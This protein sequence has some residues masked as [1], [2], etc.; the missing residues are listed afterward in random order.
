MVYT[1][2]LQLNMGLMQASKQAKGSLT[3]LNS[4][5]EQLTTQ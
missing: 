3:C 1:T 2:K 5:T 4:S